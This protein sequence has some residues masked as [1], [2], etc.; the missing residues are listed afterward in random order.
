[1]RFSVVIPTR[2]RNDLLAKCLDSL[3]P[4]KQAGA[5]MAEP[6][7]EYEVIVSDDGGGEN[8][9]A[10]LRDRY[11]WARW[12]AGPRRGPAANRNHGARQARGEWLAF[13]DDDCV[14][15]HGWLEALVREAAAGE[16]DVIEG[17]TMVPNKRD[18][19]FLHAV[20][21]STGGCYWSCNLA[22]RREEFWRIG[23]FDERFLAAGGEDMEFAWRMRRE[24]LRPCFNPDAVVLHPQRA[25]SAGGFLRRSGRRNGSCFTGSSRT[26]RRPIRPPPWWWG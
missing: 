10:M 21:N 22:V 15:D 16:R 17:R 5:T 14:A 18:S 13:I 20:E 12:T 6:D 9:E 25:Y 24:G 2:H 7:P 8:A 23:G 26:H 1:M 19:P 11:P 4:G 3:S